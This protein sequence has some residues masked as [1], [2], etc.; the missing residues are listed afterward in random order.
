MQKVSETVL[1]VPLKHLW[2]KPMEASSFSDQLLVARATIPK[3]I[4]PIRKISAKKANG[5]FI[6]NCNFLYFWWNLSELCDNPQW[7][8]F[9]LLPRSKCAGYTHLHTECII[10]LLIAP[11]YASFLSS[12]L[13]WTMHAPITITL[14]R[15]RRNPY[16]IHKFGM[17]S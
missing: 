15:Q 2:K 5:L 16:L 10:P 14:C 4:P 7:K 12:V 13:M 17:F 8:D 3:P 1:Y 6:S 11:R 9:P